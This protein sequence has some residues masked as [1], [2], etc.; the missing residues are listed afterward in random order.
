MITSI[1]A[2]DPLS[3]P[4]FL[5]TCCPD[6][7]L[8]PE[9]LKF[10]TSNLLRYV[11]WQDIGGKRLNIYCKALGITTRRQE[12]GRLLP[13]K[14]TKSI[15]QAELVYWKKTKLGWTA[16]FQLQ[17]RMQE[18]WKNV[19]DSL[20]KGAFC[21][22]WKV[23]HSWSKLGVIFSPIFTARWSLGL[24]W[25]IQALDTTYW[26][27]IR[28]DRVVM[29]NSDNMVINCDT[30]ADEKEIKLWQRWDDTICHRADQIFT[31]QCSLDFSLVSSL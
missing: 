24:M 31:T 5:A 10:C 20:E 25:P 11:F 18:C 4:S 14:Q 6:G 13:T 30:A 17:E 1:E 28:S 16:H 22:Y 3:Y 26:L 8:I 15:I 2:W 21:E 23:Y 12:K 7:P 19:N 29:I 9:E 27:T